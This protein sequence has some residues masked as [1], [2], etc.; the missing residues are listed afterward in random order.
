MAFGCASTATAAAN[1]TGSVSP[2]PAELRLSADEV[3]DRLM[4]RNAD[5]ARELVSFESQRQYNLKYSGLPYPQSAEM[6][7][8]VSYEAPGTKKFTIVSE[9]GSKLLLDKVLH[10]LLASE[11]E[12]S[13]DEANRDA[14]SLTTHNYRFMLL[15]CDS[16]SS[17]PQ[18]VM[19]ADALREDKYLYRGK[20]WIDS[21]D[22]AVTRIDVEPAKN[23]SFWIKHTQIRHR[24]QKIG[25]FY[26]PRVNETV[27]NVRLGG[28]AVLTIRYLDYKL[29][30]LSAAKGASAQ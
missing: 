10:R 2:C 29:P 19:Q 3:V 25:P 14:V 12:S 1:E 17:P 30:Q 6:H 11:K 28:T 24:Y 4:A 7:V 16:E 5:R 27:T 13:S 15:G 8:R 21:H 26:L 22:F 23:P 18:Y 9:T 20:V